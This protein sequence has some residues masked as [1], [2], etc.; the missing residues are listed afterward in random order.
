MSTTYGTIPTDAPPPELPFLSRARQRIR[1][2]IG[3]RRPWKEMM[4]SFSVPETSNAAVQRLRTNTS[5]F[6]VNYAIVVLFMLFISLLWHPV[7]LIVFTAAMF[8]WL[9][10]YF[11]RN[12]PIVLC[13]GYAVEERL[14]MVLLSIFTV[15]SLLLT[16]AMVFLVGLAAGMA[17]TVAHAVFRRTNGLVS[18]EEEGGG[19]RVVVALLQSL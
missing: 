14:V 1:S 3:I 12:D 16:H 9:F 10:L 18:E 8:A 7:S 17:A 19:G 2:G 15:V 11:L 6:H 13:G 5:H 4:A